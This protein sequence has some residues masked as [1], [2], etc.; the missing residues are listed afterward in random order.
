MPNKFGESNT[1]EMDQV[2]TTSF[3]GRGWSFPP[4]FDKSQKKVLLVEDETDIQQSLMIL[5]TT[6][7]GERVM[8]HDYGAGL[9]TMLF[10]PLT[11]NLKT[12]MTDV[13]QSAILRY[14]PRIDLDEVEM[15]DSG[16]LEGRVLITINFTIKATNSRSN[17]VFP[18]YKNE[19]TNI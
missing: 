15:D 12:Y 17:I 19:G 7:L 5:L 11:T 2:S 3:L 10:E 18:F 6:Q 8:N 14:E 13:I 9:E 1:E 4:S 16:E